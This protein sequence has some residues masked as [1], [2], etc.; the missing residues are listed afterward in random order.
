MGKITITINIY[1]WLFSIAMSVYKKTGFWWVFNPEGKWKGS[2][3]SVHPAHD[4]HGLIT[5]P[6]MAT[7]W[8]IMVYHCQPLLMVG[9]IH[10]YII[11]YIYTHVHP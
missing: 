11:I 9:Y 2:V 8:Y 4:E 5:I 6:N 10:I 3:W 1:K 7:S